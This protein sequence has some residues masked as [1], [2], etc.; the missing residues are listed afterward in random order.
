MVDLLQSSSETVDKLLE[1]LK[2]EQTDKRKLVDYV[3]QLQP[4]IDYYNSI[5]A[6]EKSIPISIIAK[7]YGM[8]ATAFNKLL[9]AFEIQYRVGSV[10]LLYAKFANKGYTVSKTF[11]KPN[12]EVVIYTH[13][14]QKGRNFIY[15]ALMYYG[16]L[17]L[18]E[19]WEEDDYEIEEVA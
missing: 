16:I 13:W 14:T 8:S 19:M 11:Q 12:G 2:R 15:H 17:P 18:S 5:L 1:Q 7:D 9:H 6:A 4:K 3:E 10:W